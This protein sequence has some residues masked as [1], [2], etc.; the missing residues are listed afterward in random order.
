MGG[1][2][3]SGSDC[4]ISTEGVGRSTLAI[5]SYIGGCVNIGDVLWIRIGIDGAGVVTGSVVEALGG[6]GGIVGELGGDGGIVVALGGV[7]GIV[8]TLGGVGGI[9]GALGGAGAG[10]CVVAFIGTFAG[11]VV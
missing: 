10:G 5:L 1:P 4:S 6:V 2:I 9:V 7:G 8:V 3:S 11:I